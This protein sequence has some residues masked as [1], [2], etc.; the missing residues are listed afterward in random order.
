[1]RQQRRKMKLTTL[2]ALFTDQL[3][4]LYDAENQILRALPKMA[5][6]AISPDLRQVLTNELE[7]SQAHVH[8]LDKIF[9]RLGVLPKGSNARA[10]EVLVAEGKD[11]AGDEAQATVFD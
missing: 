2:Q 8:R 9:L 5:K 3:K 4:D 7:Q 11:L 6:T 1:M 10:M